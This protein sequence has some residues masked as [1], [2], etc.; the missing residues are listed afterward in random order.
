[1]SKKKRFTF[2]SVNIT[3]VLDDRM[4]EFLSLNKGLFSNKREFLTKLREVRQKLM[5]RNSM[6]QDKKQMEI[7]NV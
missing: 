7:K 4:N 1:L 2:N 6:S 3:V 5:N